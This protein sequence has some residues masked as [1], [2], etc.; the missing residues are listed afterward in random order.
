MRTKIVFPC[1]LAL[2]LF[3]STG[4]SQDQPSN[5]NEIRLGYGMLTGPEMANSIMSIWPAIG[6]EIL[7]D[8]IKD[9]TCSFY[10]TP[11][12]EYNRFLKPWVSLGGSL[13]FNP[14]STAITSTNK[15]EFTYNYY[16]ITIMPK[17]TF[18]YLNKGIFSM[19]SG[20]EAGGSLILWKDRQGC[21]TMSDQGFTVAF[22]VTGFGVRIGK[23]IG[24]FME[25]GIGFRG[26]VNFGLSARF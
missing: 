6:M 1:L 13:S 26:V 10:G 2:L 18:Y 15:H 16:L 20:L 19:Y 24:G 7:K 23:D 14:I 5:K 9:Y 11:F 8:T 4:Y 3:S 12:F 17:V 25:W 21:T 22:Q